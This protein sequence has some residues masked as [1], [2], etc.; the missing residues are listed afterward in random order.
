MRGFGGGGGT[1]VFFA[2]M[3][4]IG[5]RNRGGQWPPSGFW[6]W[7]VNPGSEE[8]R[9]SRCSL[10]AETCPERWAGERNSL[11]P[12]V[13][14]C[15]PRGHAAWVSKVGRNQPGWV[16][17]ALKLGSLGVLSG[18]DPWEMIW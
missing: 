11:L 9:S 14:P 7:W 15:L 13:N 10:C 1:G 18:C 17:V 3:N 2:V 6:S 5:S 12:L 8:G 16:V 4:G